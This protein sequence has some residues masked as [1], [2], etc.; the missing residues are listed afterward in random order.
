MKYENINMAHFI[1]R[2]NRF[3]CHCRLIKS[4]EVVTVHVKNT[5]RGKEVLICLLYTSDAADD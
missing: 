4:N 1:I 3:I 5:G 2:D